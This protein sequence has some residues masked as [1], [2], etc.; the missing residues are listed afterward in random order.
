MSVT[1]SDYKD[2]QS[3]QYVSF[4]LNNEEY[5][6]PILCV[7]EIIRY[8]TLTKIPQSPEFMDGVLNLRGIV[9][10]VINMRNK[11]G[12]P[13]KE[14]DRSTRIIVVGINNRLRGI[15]VDEVS[16]VLQFNDNDIEPP[17]TLESHIKTDFISGMGKVNDGLIILLD[18]EKVLTSEENII[19]EKVLAQ[20]NA[21]IDNVPQELQEVTS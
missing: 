10:P 14:I 12:L 13:Q 4:F 7:N 19:A 15:V 11:F 21:Y 1:D 2:K 17:P 6:I 16:A 8:E 5:G 3:N 18:I 9:I 20:H